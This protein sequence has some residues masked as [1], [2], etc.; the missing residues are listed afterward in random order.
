MPFKAEEDFDKHFETVKLRWKIERFF[1][2]IKANSRPTHGI[3]KWM[4]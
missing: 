3:N 1:I 4:M 2:F